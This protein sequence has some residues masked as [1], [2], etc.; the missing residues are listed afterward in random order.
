MTIS[1]DCITSPEGVLYLKKLVHEIRMGINAKLELLI[2]SS[3]IVIP[4]I[5]GSAENPGRGI[6]KKRYVNWY[7]E[8]VNDSDTGLYAETAY[9]LRC[10]LLHEGRGGSSSKNRDYIIY[11]FPHEYP[12][13]RGINIDKIDIV[14]TPDGVAGAR[15]MG[16]TI[17][18]A[19]RL[20]TALTDACEAWL[21]KVEGD[22]DIVNRL[23]G[24]M[25]YVKIR[26]Y[27]DF[28]LKSTEY[29]YIFENDQ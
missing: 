18:N 14:Q 6:S 19:H 7:E 11:T 22:K 13:A 12:N 27:V 29:G 23:T 24:M 2:L 17:F 5:C 9:R 3:A 28:S 20:C 8:N 16:H 10:G 1:K 21:A 4:D 26:D 25:R 15:R